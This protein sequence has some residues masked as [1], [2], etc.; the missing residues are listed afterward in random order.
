MAEDFSCRL[1]FSVNWVSEHQRKHLNYYPGHI[2]GGR[3][4]KGLFDIHRHAKMC[5]SEC[6]LSRPIITTYGLCMNYLFLQ[7]TLCGTDATLSQ[8]A[9]SIAWSVSSSAFQKIAPRTSRLTTK[10]L[11]EIVGAIR[12][13]KV[14][15][16]LCRHML[17]TGNTA[18][19][20]AIVVRL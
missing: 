10:S 6:K 11:L 19:N 8:H 1:G 5:I 20:Q 16:F 12:K 15:I 2:C 4:S 18:K 7:L 14:R 13:V 3:M 17:P 9:T